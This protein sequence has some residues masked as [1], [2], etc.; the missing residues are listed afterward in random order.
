MP[1]AFSVYEPLSGTIDIIYEPSA[2]GGSVVEYPVV[3]LRG[4]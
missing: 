2:A 4:I 3:T 1:Y